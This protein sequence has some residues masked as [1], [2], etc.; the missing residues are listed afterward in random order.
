M[1]TKNESKGKKKTEIIEE[2]TI[3]LNGKTLNKS[4]SSS[5]ENKGGPLLCVI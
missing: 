1:K 2:Q 3:S 5:K 4:K